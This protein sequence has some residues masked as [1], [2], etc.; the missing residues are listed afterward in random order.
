MDFA[1]SISYD[2]GRGREAGN[3]V[4]CD[5]KACIG[6]GHG[7]ATILDRLFVVLRRPEVRTGQTD[8]HYVRSLPDIAI[9]EAGSGNIRLSVK[10]RRTAT[11][12]QAFGDLEMR[13]QQARPSPPFMLRDARTK[14]KE[15][16]EGPNVQKI[17][18]QGF[19]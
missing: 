17:R 5:N 12:A 13:Q 16:G 15:W 14:S 6:G 10:R 9:P 19:D 18:R 8:Q 7:V 1:P 3:R 2:D 11:S 4:P